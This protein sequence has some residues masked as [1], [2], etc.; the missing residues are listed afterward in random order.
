M[1]WFIS[2]VQINL[3][4][5]VR[6]GHNVYD[7]DEHPVEKVERWNEKYGKEDGF[8]A[9]LLSY[10]R[11]DECPVTDADRLATVAGCRL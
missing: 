1:K 6:F 7:D 3:D 8:Q 4:G 10:Q 9:I 2:Y 11:A 5:C